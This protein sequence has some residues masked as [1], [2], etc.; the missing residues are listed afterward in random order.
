MPIQEKLAKTQ[1]MLPQNKYFKYTHGTFGCH[2]WSRFLSFGRERP[3]GGK[4]EPIQN[5]ERATMVWV[6]GDDIAAIRTQD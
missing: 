4:G 2:Q 6:G 3:R 5:R 1:N